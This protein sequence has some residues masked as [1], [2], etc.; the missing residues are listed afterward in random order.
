LASIAMLDE[1][2]S[3]NSK[4]GLTAGL[5]RLWFEAAKP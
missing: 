3:A 5:E 4:P 1:K 2:A